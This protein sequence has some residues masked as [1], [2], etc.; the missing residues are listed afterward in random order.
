MTKITKYYLL[1]L[2]A[3]VAIFFVEG[4]SHAKNFTDELNRNVTIKDFPPKKIVS[5]SPNITEIL[6][7]L[8]LGD[9]IVGV[10]KECN[11][12]E[13][14]KKKEKVSSYM[15]FN[16]ELLVSMKPDV[17]LMSAEGNMKGQ[18]AEMERLGLTVYAVKTSKVSDIVTAINDI[19]Q[20]TDKTK[21][22]EK[23]SENIER[24]VEKVK[25]LVKGAKRKTVF[26]LVGLDPLIGAGPNTFIGDLIKVSGGE[27]IIAADGPDY[28]VMN[29]EELYVKDPDV[30]LVSSMGSEVVKNDKSPMMKKFSKLTASKKGSIFVVDADIL[31]RPS[32]RI[33]RALYEILKKI[34]PEILI[35]DGEE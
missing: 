34:H 28:P 30:I 27:N 11:Y 1:P 20:V 9:K 19:G 14:A 17:I 22:A 6:F 23:L 35:K 16:E 32:Y 12:P 2:M 31:C 3:A 15:N 7:E 21:E 24:A 4:T 10:T 18:M 29:I 25:G 8:G 26:C 13:A 5:L 33:T